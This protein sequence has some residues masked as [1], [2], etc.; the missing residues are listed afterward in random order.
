MADWALLVFIMKSIFGSVEQMGKGLISLVRHTP[1]SQYHQ[2]TVMILIR[3]T[4]VRR[5]ST[6]PCHWH[7]LWVITYSMNLG[8]PYSG[9]ATTFSVHSIFR[10]PREARLLI[11]ARIQKVS[12]PQL[13][14]I[15]SVPYE[16]M[17][18]PVPFTFMV[19]ISVSF[20]CAQIQY[21]YSVAVPTKDGSKF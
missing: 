5:K 10:N 1:M 20:Q 14:M 11:S 12:S 21:D 6:A 3:E 2:W 17:L 16:G 13:M 15:F 9:M 8:L 7:Y 19:I 18:L 4:S